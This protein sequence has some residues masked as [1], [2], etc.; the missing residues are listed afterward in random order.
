[1]ERKAI[2]RGLVKEIALDPQT[3]KGIATLYGLP[4]AA[5][6]ENEQGRQA[7][8]LISPC[9]AIAGAGVSAIE[10]E[11]STQIRPFE[12]RIRL[13]ERLVA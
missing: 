6:P 8:M 1:M 3:G 5:L 11:F 7:K 13:R 12:V 10:N 4:L 9:K 2:L